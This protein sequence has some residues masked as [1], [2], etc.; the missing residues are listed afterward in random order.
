MDI[1]ALRRQARMTPLWG[2]LLYLAAG[3]AWVA[4]GDWL[5]DRWLHGSEHMR[6]WQSFKGWLF[7][8][9]SSL[10]AG[11][12]LARM[13]RA[14]QL[15][16]A[17]SHELA[18]V[19]HHA[20]AGI[21]RVDPHSLATL[22]ANDRLCGWLGLSLEALRGQ[23][24]RD[25]VQPADLAQARRQLQALLTGRIQHYQCEC[26]RRPAGGGEPMPVL[27]NVSLVP[28]AVGM[29]AHLVCVLQ[30]TGEVGAAR[31][32]LTHSQH[33]LGLALSGSGS[34]LWDWDLARQRSTDSPSLLQLLR[35]Q[36]PPPE[37]GS[38]L[39]ARL[40]A[41]DRE[42]IQAAVDRAIASGQPF[43]ETARLQRFDG[44]W[45]WFHARGQRHPGR[46]R[47]ARVLLRHPDR[48]ERAP[49]RRGAPAPGR[50]GGGQ[51]HRGRGGDRRGQ[52]H[53]VGERR[54]HA[55]AGLHRAGA[56]GPDAARVQVRPARQGLLPGD[57]GQHGAHRPLAG[58]DLE[59]AQERRDLSRA[60]VVVRGAGR[61]GR[62]HA[63][64]V[65]VHRH[66]RGKSASTSGWSSWR[67][68]TP[69]PGCPTGCI[70]ASSCTTWCCRRSAAA[71]SWPCCC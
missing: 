69:S 17:L 26:P 71:S 68:A 20:P 3:A 2:M 51:H 44:T 9:A 8:L 22:W 32:A 24:L 40:H 25:L 28:G 52:P 16:S 35:H 37:E 1:D 10:L 66:L 70:S 62:G 4:A 59:P 12:L 36:G 39:L 14:E 48:P 47:P 63:L 60:H 23:P 38:L 11:W 50:H 27:C 29:P 64:R 56:A 57:V 41:D 31:A 19:A 6:W 18:Q 42:R 67:I 53:P 43:D 45:C 33:V 61:A 5:L 34:G 49:R 58:R 46:A 13:R 21:A 65:H 55:A 7:V 30:D 54:I 15:R